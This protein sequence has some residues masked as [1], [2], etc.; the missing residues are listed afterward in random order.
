MICCDLQEE[1]ALREQ[2]EN[3][4][5]EVHKLLET[6]Q[7]AAS[8]AAAA[9]VAREQQRR[10][11]VEQQMLL[12]REEMASSMQ[13]ASKSQSEMAAQVEELKARMV[14]MERQHKEAQVGGVCPWRSANHVLLL[15]NHC[16]CCWGGWVAVT[17]TAL[18]QFF[19][20]KL[21]TDPPPSWRFPPPCR[22]SRRARWRT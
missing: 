2:V 8:V 21:C 15:W 13:G 3:Q 10:A 1:K 11:V 14:V 9:D 18:S 7:A 19:L 4:L 6:Q 12:L 20:P 5:A 17:R 16:G 22:A